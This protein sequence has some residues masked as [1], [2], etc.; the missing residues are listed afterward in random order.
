MA[1]FFGNGLSLKRLVLLMGLMASL[2]LPLLDLVVAAHRQTIDV[3][4]A[5]AF[6]TPLAAFFL[7][8]LL[9]YLVGVVGII[10]PLAKFGKMEPRL[11]LVSLAAALAT[12]A[13][14]Y[15]PDGAAWILPI[16][17][18]IVVALSCVVFTL[19]YFALEG[20]AKFPD[21]CDMF[22]RLTLGLPFL[23][24]ITF[25]FQWLRRE[26]GVMSASWGLVLLLG[27]YLILCGVVALVCSRPGSTRKALPALLGFAAA[28]VLSPAVSYV[29]EKRSKEATPL[30]TSAAP[31]V[32]HVI[33]LTVDTLRRDALSCYGGSN[34]TPNIDGLAKDSIVFTNAYAPAPWTLPSFASMFTG[35]SPWVHRA[36]RM[37]D[38]LPHGLP[39]LA[40]NLGESGYITAAIGFN[41]F[42]T[43]HVSKRSMGRGF[44]YYDFYPKHFGPRTLAMN[45]F[46]HRFP[47]AFGFEATTDELTRMAAAW[48]TAHSDQSFF[49]WLHYLDPHIPYGPPEEFFPVGEPDPVVGARYTA[50]MLD[51]FRRGN[52][53]L[54]P[55]TTQWLKELYLGEVRYVDNRIGRFLSTLENL[56][57]YRDSLIILTTDH[58]EE[59]FDHGDL[60]HGQSLYNELIHIPLIIKLP[61]SSFTGTV[62]SAV[63]TLGLLPTV[64]E[65]CDIKY[66]KE[67]LS[68]VSLVPYWSSEG[69]P[70]PDQPIFATGLLCFDEREAVIFDGWKYIRSLD[71]D[72][73]ELYDL[74]SDPGEAS[75]VSFLHSDKLQEAR[76]LLKAKQAKSRALRE[77]Y[78]L[79][80]DEP[81]RF[82][83]GEIELLRSL[84]YAQ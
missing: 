80:V 15:N 82:D 19:V 54:L 69:G 24:L 13:W 84:G 74:R 41:Y 40:Q 17:I 34:A 42:L 51:R 63:S 12:P 58:G 14:L 31:T 53:R 25:A 32:P 39:T 47:N 50:E 75:N 35:V 73:E 57:I 76:A 7:V 21:R 52:W 16:R 28:V 64:L 37:R 33:L 71:R 81:V 27:V 20:A 30:M 18:L 77:L 6:T 60:D 3:S 4:S 38:A 79:G 67:A 70:P 78:G 8:V 72:R 66:R 46:L 62:D 83:E 26:L 65:L 56:G 11:G 2:S 1:E 29:V 55:K 49:F 44:Q 23:L 5:W 45:L 9:A 68:G 36:T 43:P 61:R 22:V 59:H 48:L 10:V